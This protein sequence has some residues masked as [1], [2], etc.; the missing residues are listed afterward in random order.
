VRFCFLGFRLVRIFLE[1]LEN[2]TKQKQNCCPSFPANAVENFPSC[3][4]KKKQKLMFDEMSNEKPRLYF[5]ERRKFYNSLAPEVSHIGRTSYHVLS[6]HDPLTP[7][8]MLEGLDTPAN[9]GLLDLCREVLWKSLQATQ[10]RKD[11][12]KKEMV[13]YPRGQ[14]AVPM[15][16]VP[17]LCKRPLDSMIAAHR[18]VLIHEHLYV[19][20]S[21]KGQ[22]CNYI[23]FILAQLVIQWLLVPISDAIWKTNPIPHWAAVDWKYVALIG[24]K[25]ASNGPIISATISAPLETTGRNVCID[26]DRVT[27]WIICNSSPNSTTDTQ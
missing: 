12:I 6:V 11:Q 9:I 25:A 16:T 17:V 22:R 4:L 2:K 23:T 3:L 27:K 8:E 10:M 19:C 24:R 21:F 26:I 7:R 18:L 13:D 15:G 14:H 5:P 1:K 20:M